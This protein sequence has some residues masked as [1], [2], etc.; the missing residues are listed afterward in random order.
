MAFLLIEAILHARERIMTFDQ[1]KWVW[2]N[3]RIIPWQEAT[4]HVS[5]HA[6]HYG[7]GVFEGMRCYETADGPAIFRLD[8]H[9]DRLFESAAVHGMQIP[10]SREDLSEAVC[11]LIDRNGFKSCYVRPLCFYGSSSL[12]LHPAK[13]PVETVILVWPWA[14]YLGAE[15]LE[16]GVRVT[17]SPWK[18]FHSDMMPTTAK[19][20]GQYVNSI[21]AVREAMSRGFDEALLLDIAGNVAEGSGENLFVV[22]DGHLLTNDERHS[23]LLGITRNAVIQ[24]AR[25]LGYN[26]NVGPLSL[27]DLLQAD[28]AFFTGTAAEVTPIREVDGTLINGG[29]RGPITQAIQSVFFAVTAGRN[30]RYRDWLTFVAQTAGLVH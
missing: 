12:G 29:Q 25:D 2:R 15:G 27:D 14:P 24:I 22:R 9:L 11:E 23:I 28:E 18:K 6:L 17:V 16:H 7:S 5:S 3:G 20:S 10:Y 21:L 13:C 8:E 30:A 4:T 26:V 1:S 19:A